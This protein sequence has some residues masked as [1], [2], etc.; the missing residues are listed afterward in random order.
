M[1]ISYYQPY[2]G[3]GRMIYAMSARCLVPANLSE[4]TSIDP[5]Q[6]SHTYVISRL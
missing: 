6:G 2:S 1:L 5:K 3:R 4:M